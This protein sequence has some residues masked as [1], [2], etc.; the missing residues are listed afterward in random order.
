MTDSLF[1]QF[2]HRV[3]SAGDGRDAE[4][5][6]TDDFGVFSFLRGVRDRALMLEL[7]KK[8][9]SV[10]ALGYGWLERVEFD[11]SAG[12]TLYFGSQKVKIIGRNLAMELR[13]NVRL[14]DGLMRHRIPWIREAG[15][16]E[17]LKAGAASL[18]I[19]KITIE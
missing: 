16:P 4:A 1:K 5:E 19:E 10:T 7:R 2:V 17:V 15:E 18:V 3:P 6:D 11:P 13:P 8:D 14:L 9:G 12:L